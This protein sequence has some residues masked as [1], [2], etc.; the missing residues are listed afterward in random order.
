MVSVSA[1]IS[2]LKAFFDFRRNRPK[3]K[4]VPVWRD[5]RNNYTGE[6]VHGI[7]IHVT[8]LGAIAVTV[9]SVGFK[10]RGSKEI[11]TFLLPE[12]PS[13]PY[14]LEPRTSIT[15][16]IPSQVRNYQDFLACGRAFA[17][18][19]CKLTFTGSGRKFVKDIKLRIAAT[20]KDGSP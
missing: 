4:V 2:V 6:W 10:I 1:L 18:T 5:F 14:R 15:P 19:Q 7:G 12:H 11:L 9:E 8:N 20:K 3:L 17:T 16:S 13:L